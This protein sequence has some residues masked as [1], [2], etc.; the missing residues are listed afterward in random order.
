MTG[1]GAA[2]LLGG[3][4]Y[5]LANT[6]DG[7]SPGARRITL[8]QLKTSHE[9]DRNLASMKKAFEQAGR[10]AAEWILFPEGML[11][12]YHGDID[13]A[14]VESAFVKC[15]ELC[16]AHKVTA[17]IGTSWKEN[18]KTFNQVRMI[19]ASGGL[20][21]AY[22]KRCLTCGDAEWST[23][24][25]TDLVFS[26][27]G[28][29]FGV[30]VCNDLWVTPGYTD[31]P[32]P[33][34]TLKQSRAGAQVIFQSVSSGSAQRFRAYHESNLMARAAEAKCPIIT[35]NA[36]TE[37]AVNATSGVVGTDFSYLAMLPRDRECVRTVE[38][39]PA[40]GQR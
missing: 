2:A 28:I 17:L 39:T 11:S 35:V 23:P 36:F 13:Q 22:A 4:E 6:P 19:D 27:N 3:A 29:K 7:K 26:A 30:L 5:S 12:G 15:V 31:G 8:A 16:R 10:E 25:S 32:D 40:A 14:A 21:G 1:A 9:L 33:R 37:P 18:G 20:I 24:G 38:F 34:L